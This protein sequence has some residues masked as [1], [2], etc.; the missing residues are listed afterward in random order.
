MRLRTA[1]AFALCA[2][3]LAV[4]L[5]RAARAG[6]HVA[7]KALFDRGLADMSAGRFES[8]CPAIAESY[9]LDPRPGTLFTLAEC[10]AKRGRTAT[11]VELY[12]DYLSQYARLPR[13]KQEQQGHRKQIAE[14]QRATLAPQVARLTVLLAPDA[15]PGTTL[16]RDGADVAPAA[17]GIGLP[18][19]P[20]EHVLTVREPDRPPLDVRVTI[21]AGQ[22]KLLTLPRPPPPPLFTPRRIGALGAAGAGV[23][24]L[25][26]GAVTGG[27]TLAKKGVIDA[28]CDFKGDPYGC[29]ATGLAATSAAKPLSVASTV[30]LVVGALGV[31]TAL[32]L[33]FT[34]RTG[35]DAR[36]LGLG[37]R[38]ADGGTGRHD[39]RSPGGLL[40]RR[41]LALRAALLL[42]VGVLGAT[43]SCMLAAGLDEPWHQHCDATQV[44]CDGVCA[45]LMSD[46]D[47]C[48]ACG[49]PCKQGESCCG[50]KCAP[51]ATDRDNCGACG[52][53]RDGKTCCAGSCV[54]PA[55]EQDKCGA[56]GN[57][58]S[59]GDTC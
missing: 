33:F 14:D 52:E 23:V 50:G 5:P 8:G 51:T 26:V 53:R 17:I 55:R 21:G 58:C 29:D 43:A 18:V 56:C 20:G 11:A 46:E 16:T 7:A 2:L 59:S 4:A 36:A 12:D 10:E 31:G 48:G 15:P 38:R 54:D 24:G 27:L 42:C 57:A 39:L 25:V 37:R 47:N 32:T 44:L 6:D 30:G 49:S 41:P 13:D 35:S 28:H 1:A 22:K 9:R 3:S 40:M 19:D 34:E 45:D